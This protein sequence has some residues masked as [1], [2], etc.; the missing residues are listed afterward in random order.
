MF[1]E[2]EW[3]ERL[4]TKAEEFVG[5]VDVSENGIF[6]V[7]NRQNIID[8]LAKIVQAA[9][10]EGEEHAR[11]TVREWYEPEILTFH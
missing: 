3:S 11:E 7:R 5:W 2:Q 8:K 6:Q 10:D 4:K 9:M 1:K